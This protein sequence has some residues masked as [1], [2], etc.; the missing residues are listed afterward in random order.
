MLFKIN[1]TKIPVRNI[2]IKE[3]A[4]VDFIKSIYTQEIKTKYGILDIIFDKPCGNT[5]KSPD[6][7]IVC[8]S[9]VIVVEVDEFQHKNKSNKGQLYSKE[10]EENR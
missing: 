3:N 8:E 4:V 9:Y 5:N 6:I 2:K 7:V 10:N 1:P